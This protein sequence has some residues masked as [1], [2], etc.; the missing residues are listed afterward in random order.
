MS[1]ATKT[2]SSHVELRPPA[3]EFALWAAIRRQRGHMLAG[4][5]FFL[6]IALGSVWAVYT[7]QYYD[8]LGSHERGQSSTA[9]DT[10]RNLAER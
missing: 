8:N 5:L 2:I 3:G 10:N 9:G 4:M 7:M 1:A 6:V